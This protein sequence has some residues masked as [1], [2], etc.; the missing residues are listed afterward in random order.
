[1]SM[2]RHGQLRGPF[3]ANEHLL[4]DILH[5][6]LFCAAERRSRQLKVALP[7]QR[8]LDGLRDA[9]VRYLGR[10]I[11][12]Y[13]QDVY[14][15]IH[16]CNK[17]A[18]AVT[19][20]RKHDLR[21]YVRIP[22]ETVWSFIHS[23]RTSGV[24]LPGLLQ[25]RIED[26][27]AGC[28]QHCARLWVAKHHAMYIERR[29]LV[30]HGVNHLCMVADPSTHSKR[31]TMVAVCWSWEAGGAAHGDLQ[32][33]PPG[34]TMLPSEQALPDDLA[35]LAASNRLERVAA[36]RQLQWLSNT[37]HGLGNSCW[38]DLDAFRL[39]EDWRVEAVMDGHARVIVPGEATCLFCRCCEW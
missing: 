36:F 6:A 32:I 17:A 15:K 18:P 33:I 37:I 31:E 26:V 21:Q 3:D 19:S 34:S 35:R 20:P 16:R 22:A 9:F 5:F 1:M 8:V 28:S 39:P 25:T 4:V 23:A 2:H 12:V 29:A 14:L 7:L 11:D 30:M 24:C 13:I 38:P 27:D 10:E